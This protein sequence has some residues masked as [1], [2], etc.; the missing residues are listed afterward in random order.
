MTGLLHSLIAADRLLFH[1]VNQVWTHPALDAFMPFVTD[2]HKSRP[3]LWLV[4]PAALAA[5]I[6]RK[7][8]LA[9]RTILALALVVGLTDTLSYRVIKPLVHRARPEGA[10][11]AVVLRAGSGGDG[12]PSNHAA[13]TFAAAAF[14]APL[15]PA[16]S[17]P[18]FAVAAVV[19]YSRVY[20][21]AHFP[22]DVAGGAALGL[23]IG[24]LAGAALRRLGFF[25]KRR[26]ALAR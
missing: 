1:K 18:L 21:G 15:Y 24:W 23:L 17:V 14:L 10:G 5:W 19:A 6:Y 26:A 2:L 3:V 16:L 13:N 11:V 9:A 4:L 20:V 25:K 7:R 12:F 8:E 22:L